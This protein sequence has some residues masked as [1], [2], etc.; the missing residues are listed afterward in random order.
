MLLIMAVTLYTS[1]SR[2]VLEALGKRIFGIY[3]IVSG[4]VIL[5]SF[6][7]NGMVTATQYFLNFG[8]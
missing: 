7:N 3:N 5:F 1:T 2:V 4:V 8:L 6:V